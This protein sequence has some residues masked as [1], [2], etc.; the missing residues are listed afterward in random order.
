MIRV[1][2]GKIQLSMGK[3]KLISH[4]YVGK[5]IIL[6]IVPVGDTNPQHTQMRDQL[7]DAHTA[8]PFTSI[9]ARS[10]AYLTAVRD[11]NQVLHIGHQNGMRE[12]LWEGR[13]SLADQSRREGE[14]LASHARPPVSNK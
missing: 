7:Q 11:L 1:G 13:A 14:G 6:R 10:D 2:L 9:H 8:V 4:N 5:Y 3:D 12:R